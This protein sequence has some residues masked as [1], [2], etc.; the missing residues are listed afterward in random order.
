MSVCSGWNNI[1]I[2]QFYRIS[3]RVEE[4]QSIHFIVRLLIRA[5]ICLMNSIGL[6]PTYAS[7]VKSL[8]PIFDCCEYSFITSKS[9]RPKNEA[10]RAR[11]GLGS[12]RLLTF[13]RDK[14]AGASIEWST[15][16]VSKP[17]CSHFGRNALLSHFGHVYI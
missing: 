3:I 6:V 13:F 15:A 14:S 17:Q 12:G 10:S 2:V 8:N 5:K 1:M 9:S 4:L 11:K 16:S 7:V